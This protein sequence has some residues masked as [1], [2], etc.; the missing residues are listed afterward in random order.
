MMP[1]LIGDM[2]DYDRWKASPYDDLDD[3]FEEREQDQ[4]EPDKECI[5]D[6][7]LFTG[8]HYRDECFT[9]EDCERERE[10]AFWSEHTDIEALLATV[11]WIQ[12]TQ[13]EQLRG[14]VMVTIAKMVDDARIAVGLQPIQLCGTCGQEGRHEDCNELPF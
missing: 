14:Q 6:D 2:G 9:A 8:E 3:D 1:V 12:S 11:N 13:L 5:G 4:D 10:A 7:C